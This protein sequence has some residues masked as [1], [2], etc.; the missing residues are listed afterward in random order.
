MHISGS[1]DTSISGINEIFQ[2]PLSLPSPSTAS[3]LSGS[4]ICCAAWERA[5]VE[6]G[7]G[8][9]CR[10]QQLLTVLPGVHSK[11]VE[12][13]DS[14]KTLARQSLYF[15]LKGRKQTVLVLFLKL[16]I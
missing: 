13:Q 9:G 10:G 16:G 14:P 6:K 12:S 5:A 4:S 11:R 8:S 1:L 3:Q 15:I 2:I 7:W